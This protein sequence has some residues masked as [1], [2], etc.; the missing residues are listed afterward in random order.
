[1]NV[2]IKAVSVDDVE[3]NLLLIEAMAKELNIEVYSY[4]DPLKVLK[5]CTNIDFDIAFV[6]YMMPNLDGITLITKIREYHPEIPVIMITGVNAGIELKI[7]AIESGATEFL[8]K[9]L[10]MP[11]FKARVKNLIELRTMNILLKDR[12]QLLKRE[13]AQATEKLIQRENE[14]LRIL[15]RVSDFKDYE[16]GNHIARVA[17]YSRFLAEKIGESHSFQEL[18]WN[19]APLHDIG[20]VGIP[21]HII[22]KKHLLSPEEMHIMKDHPLIGYHILENSESPILQCGASISRSHH[23]KYDGSGYPCGT[24]GKEIPLEG[25]ITAVSDVFDALRS[26]RPYK[27]A[28]SL[29]MIIEYFRNNRSLHF[30]PDLTDIFLEN[31]DAFEK[32]FQSFQN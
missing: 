10:N 30:D 24:L 19:A 25:R 27:K 1:M 3:S 32:I 9:P 29:E 6:D 2:K 8:T 17:Y 31:T 15:G 22:K 20:K 16:T 11:E 4:S 26:E 23:E 21:D 5:D 14:T 12:A 7:R 13:V 28:W 18:L